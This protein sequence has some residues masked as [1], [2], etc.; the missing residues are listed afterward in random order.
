MY[1]SFSQKYLK[2]CHKKHGRETLFIKKNAVLIKGLFFFFSSLI[3]FKFIS[4]CGGSSSLHWLFSPCSEQGLWIMYI[5]YINLAGACLETGVL[6]LL[7]LVSAQHSMSSLFS[8]VLI[9]F[10]CTWTFSGCSQQELL[11]NCCVQ[12]SHCCSY[13]CCRT[14]AL[15]HR[16]NTC[17][18]QACCS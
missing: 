10:C 11:S 5:K 4:G 15:E 13:S 7:V 17:V 16:L 12:A 9:W 8:A 2:L 18:A 3:I 14:Q 6:T 1:T